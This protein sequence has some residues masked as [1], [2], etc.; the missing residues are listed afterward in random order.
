M[1][2]GEFRIHHCRWRHKVWSTIQIEKVL[3]GGIE[4][5]DTITSFPVFRIFLCSLFLFPEEQGVRG[6][7]HFSTKGIP[8][9]S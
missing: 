2:G 3:T 5:G 6:H 8:I 1:R 9:S 4:R 7:W